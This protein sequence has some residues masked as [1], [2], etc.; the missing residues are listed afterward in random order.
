MRPG[1][2]ERADHDEGEDDGDL[3]VAGGEEGQ[4]L[5]P[6]HDLVP[7]A[8]D[9]REAVAERVALGRLALEERDLLGS[10]RAAAPGEAEV[11]LVALLVEI[12]PD[13]RPA[14]EVGEPGADDGVDERRPDQIAGDVVALAEEDQ[15]ARRRQAPQDEQEREQRRRT[16]RAA[17]TP[18][19]RA[20]RAMKR[21]MSSAMRWSGLSAG[22]PRRRMR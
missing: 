11:G 18:M 8:D 12:E 6:R 22:L 4:L 15:R 9:A 3:G 1:E 16:G 21:R 17:P 13:Q 5:L 10:S 7:V 19:S 14:D 2:I 20:C